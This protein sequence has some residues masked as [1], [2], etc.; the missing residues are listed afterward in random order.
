MIEIVTSQVGQCRSLYLTNQV[1]ENNNKKIIYITLEES[2]V[3]IIR[4]IKNI[5]DVSNI[6]LTDEYMKGGLVKSFPLG[7]SFDIIKEYLSKNEYDKLII[8]SVYC[9]SLN[10]DNTKTLHSI[11]KHFIGSN[12]DITLS[13]QEG[14]YNEMSRGQQIISTLKDKI[15][16]D[17]YIKGNI[18]ITKVYRENNIIKA[19][20]N[21]EETKEIIDLEKYDKVKNYL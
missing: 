8:D 13:I 15:L 6:L 4:K 5:G 17:E 19:I 20:I 18:T 3:N 2:E 21:L 1:I 7:A 10:E 11:L 9:I 16:I 14:K 12:K